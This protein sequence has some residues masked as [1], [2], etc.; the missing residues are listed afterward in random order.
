M[1][2]SLYIHIPFCQR[3]CPYCDF[4]TYAG[5][6]WQFEP[7][8]GAL[9]REIER[10]G[11]ARERP[12]VHTI[13][14]GGGTPT[15]LPLDL[16]ARLLEACRRSFTVRDDAEITSEANPGTVDIARFDGLAA[17]GVNRL[18]LGTQSFDDAELRFLGRIHTAGEIDSAYQAA[19][20]AGFANINLDLMFALP[21]QAET[22]WRHSLARALAW[23]P[24]HLSLYALTIEDGTPFAE[25]AGAGRLDYP[26]PDQAAD[27]YELAAALLA[28]NGYAQYEISN[29]ALERPGNSELP[30]KGTSVLSAQPPTFA[31]RHN[32]TYWRNEAYLGFG[33][34]A[35]SSEGGR[36]WAN[37]RPVPE[38]VRRMEESQ[39]EGG[40]VDFMEVIDDRLAMGETMMLGLRLVGEGVSFER[41]R[42]R[43]QLEMREVYAEEIADL[44][45]MG[46]LEVLP[47]RIRLTPRARL[48]G[49]QVFARFLP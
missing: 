14:L 44:A 36:R 45:R 39:H 9:V 13:F 22:T 29:W 40:T 34:G 16:L 41:F 3:K 2:L 21:R 5:L 38:Y 37:V 10:A 27:H 43:H 20:D 49:N 6:S 15:V 46:L 8:V 24:E 11:K 17:L 12:E 35:H 19:R 31:C 47:E 7:L 48:L 32:L 33:P 4:N 30:P 18:S 26:D 23:S 1:P 28:D 42:R 25:L